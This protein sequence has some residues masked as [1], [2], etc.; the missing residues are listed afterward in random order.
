MRISTTLTL[1]GAALCATAAAAAQGGGIFPYPVHQKVMDNGL[2]VVAIP[3]DS[4]GIVAFY[5]VVRTGSRDEVEEGHSGFAHFFEHMMF[6]GTESYSQDEYNDILKSMGADSNA[7][8]SDDPTVYHIVGPASELETLFAIEAD[9]FQ[10][11]EYSEEAFRTEAGAIL[12]EYS[13]SASS[14]F[15]PLFEKLRETAFRTHTYRHTTIGFLDDIKQMPERYEYSLRFFDR[16]YRPENVVVLV[17]GDIDPQRVFALA[18]KHYGGWERGYEAPKVVA[19]PPP[20]GPQRDQV[21]WPA[22]TN[23]YLMIGYRT[24][25]FAPDEEWAAL[26]VLAQLLFSESAPLYQEL[27]VDEQWV[28][29]VSGSASPHRDPYLFTISS[30]VRSDELLPKVEQ[31]IARHIAELQKQPVDAPRLERVKSHIRYAFALSLDS[32]SAVAREVASVLWLTGEV[33]PLN[34]YYAAIQQVTPPAVQRVAKTVF[35]DKGKTVV[36]LAHATPP[37]AEGAVEQNPQ[38]ADEGGTPR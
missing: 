7:F 11:L 12:G 34:D 35:Q 13:K 27:V 19:E 20:Q 38:G 21:A 17:V 30:R 9:R 14:P 24:P 23:P 26:A 32:P 10:N 6:R 18:Q 1:L 8:T 25:A 2:Q 28:D 29:F 37:A 3:Y 5:T 16:F 15:L 33:G 31:A 36:T 22:P 4:P